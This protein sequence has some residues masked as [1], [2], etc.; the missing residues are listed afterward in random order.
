[1]KLCPTI[2][3]KKLPYISLCFVVIGYLS[4]VFNRYLPVQEGWFQYDCMLIKS[5]KLPYKDFYLH[6]QPLYL[7]FVYAVQKIFGPYIIVLRVYGVIERLVIA[8]LILYVLRKQFSLND[9]FIATLFGVFFYSSFNVDMPYSYY[10]TALLLSLISAVLFEIGLRDCE[11]V[12]F[13]YILAGASVALL[14]FTKQSIGL[15]FFVGLLTIL[16]VYYLRLNRFRALLIAFGYYLMGFACV[17]ISMISWLAINHAIKPYYNIIFLASESKGSLLSILFG[18]VPRLLKLLDPLYVTLMVIGISFTYI[19]DRYNNRSK[20]YSY[21]DEKPLYHAYA[22]MVVI[23]YA[24]AYINKYLISHLWL[25]DNIY[26]ISQYIILLSSLSLISAIIYYQWLWYVKPHDNIYKVKLYWVVIGI[27]LFYSHGMSGIL[28]VQ[29]FVFGLPLSILLWW[30]T[31]NNLKIRRYVKGVSILIGLLII[32][33][34]TSIKYVRPYYWWGWGEPDVR[35]AK[36][37]SSIPALRGMRI[38]LRTKQI[39]EQIYLLVNTNTS[40]EDEVFFFPHNALLNV[41]TEKTYSAY[42]PVCYF[43]VCADQYAIQVA[44]YLE[45]NKPKMILYMNFPEKAWKTHEEIF[46]EGKTSGQRE[47]QK[48]ITRLTKEG[49]Y[50]KIALIEDATNYPIEI[51]KRIDRN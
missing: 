34:L 14:F 12:S 47:I 51:L 44:N 4:F 35:A 27:L 8:C 43:D 32:F 16:L 39:Y 19:L 15:V 45:R 20:I 10:Q 6:I 23:C 3:C 17:V 9:S 46:R 31:Y 25:I 41:L 30:S 24:Y 1:M 49:Y 5:G 37:V 33:L 7:Y 48:T 21:I 40:S 28:E 38:S 50:Q 2:T 26:N 42:T 11:K 36:E 22:I 18:F 13:S 29:A